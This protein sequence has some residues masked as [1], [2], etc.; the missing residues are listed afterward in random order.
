MFTV[1]EL[2][3]DIG[4]VVVGARAVECGL[5]DAVGSIREAMAKV[6]ELI[7]GMVE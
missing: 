2:S 5:I 3:Q 6:D 4:S 1:G 7:E